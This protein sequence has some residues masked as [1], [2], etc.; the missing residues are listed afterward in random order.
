MFKFKYHGV[1]YVL[2]DLA[3]IDIF[4]L[5]KTVDE[6]CMYFNLL[7][8]NNKL[9]K[10]STIDHNT[11]MSL[12][13]TLIISKKIKHIEG[14]YIVSNTSTTNLGINIIEDR[15]S[16]KHHRQIVKD[17]LKTYIT[18]T[19]LIAQQNY[20][21]YSPKLHEDYVYSDANWSH[22]DASLY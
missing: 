18:S 15:G 10:L 2:K 22:K 3:I 8:Y 14:K 6:F 13:R 7:K 16:I 11:L 4:K 20:K 17:I 1:I 21:S 12:K 19:P 5:I 9:D